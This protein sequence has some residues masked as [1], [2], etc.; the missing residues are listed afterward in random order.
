MLELALLAVRPHS[1]VRLAGSCRHQ[2]GFAHPHCMHL[3]LLDD[4]QS[5]RLVGGLQVDPSLKSARS[6]ESRIDPFHLHRCSNDC[7]AIAVAIHE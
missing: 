1:R 2:L 6:K 7:E 3:L 4:V 5:L